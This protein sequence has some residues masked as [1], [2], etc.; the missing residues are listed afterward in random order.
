MNQRIDAGQA[1]LNL[2]WNGQNGDLPDPVP[3]DASDAQLR[4][5]A[6]EALRNG[7]IPG[8]HI[9]RGARL[10]DFVVDRFG[11]TATMPWHRIFVRPKTPF[12]GAP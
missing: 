12:G 2:T 3:Y 8:I 5:M 7:D 10:D 4:A 1:R 6:L 11:P 9:D